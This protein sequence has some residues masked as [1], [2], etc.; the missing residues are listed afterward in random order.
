MVRIA[1]CVCVLPK[2]CNSNLIMRK[3]DK[4]RE[5]FCKILI[6]LKIFSVTKNRKSMGVS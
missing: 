5:T 6:V 4:Y 2:T 3:T 1:L